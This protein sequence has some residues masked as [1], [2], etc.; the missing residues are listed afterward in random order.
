MRAKL[1][2]PDP[3]FGLGNGNELFDDDLRFVTG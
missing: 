2:E 3:V 1:L